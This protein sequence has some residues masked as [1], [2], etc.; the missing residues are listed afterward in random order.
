MAVELPG[1]S[2]NQWLSTRWEGSANPGTS[3]A[4]NVPERLEGVQPG[5]MPPHPHLRGCRQGSSITLD[6]DCNPFEFSPVIIRGETVFILSYLLLLFFTSVALFIWRSL[7]SCICCQ[8]LFFRHSVAGL[9]SIVSQSLRVYKSKEPPIELSA[10]CFRLGFFPYLQCSVTFMSSPGPW[11]MCLFHLF[12]GLSLLR[13]LFE[14]ILLLGQLIERTCNQTVMQNTHSWENSS[15][16]GSLCFIFAS[17]W[18]HSFSVIDLF[19]WDQI[20]SISPFFFLKN[21]SP[22][23]ERTAYKIIWILFLCLSKTSSALLP[24][25]MMPS[26]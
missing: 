19:L 17:C 7:N 23:Q 11:T 18:K 4:S 26:M 24:N 15:F 6:R 5:S 3:G 13:P 12:R 10:R 8:C 25:A 22:M 1:H 16:S 20:M 9:R 2:L 21:A 14:V